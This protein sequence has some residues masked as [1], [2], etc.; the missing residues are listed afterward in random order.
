MGSLGLFRGRIGPPG[1]GVSTSSGATDKAKAKSDI[2]AMCEKLL[3]NTVIDG[4][5]CRHDVRPCWS[6][7]WAEVT[8]QPDV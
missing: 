4:L 5:F 1:Q 8:N 6:R 3:A 2:E 7:R